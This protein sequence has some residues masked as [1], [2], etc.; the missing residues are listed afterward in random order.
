MKIIAVD[1]EKDAL[2]A[3]DR[4]IKRIEP[5]RE[6]ACFDSAEDALAYAKKQKVDVAFLD[7]EMPEK[8]GLQLAKELKEI[9]G[10][11]NIVFVTGHSHYTGEAMG[12]RASGYVMK[13]INP[14]RV[15]E[16]LE[17]LRHPV[18]ESEHKVRI[19]CF[20]N[21]E[22]FVDGKPVEFKRSK[23]KEILA[24]LVDRNGAAVKNKELAAIL[25]EDQAYTR[26]MQSHLQTLIVE[27]LR[28]LDAVGVKDIIIK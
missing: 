2:Q 26:S 9:H 18:T 3:L 21:F 27:M 24:Y 20:G 28:A 10:A 5:N 8:N 13:P 22:V 19:Q 4:A 11:T 15:Q 1:D 17:N 14:K 12:M 16:E 6:V 7:I 25:W 23:S